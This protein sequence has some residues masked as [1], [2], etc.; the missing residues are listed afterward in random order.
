MNQMLTKILILVTGII[1]VVVG[2][3]VYT[4]GEK[5]KKN[6]KE[7]ATA[8]VVEIQS[9]ID[10][11]S[12]NDTWEYYPIL[13]YKVGDKTYQVEGP[14]S[15]NE[16]KYKVGQEVSILYNANN[17]KEYLIQGEKSH[18]KLLS[19]VFVAAGIIT[20]ILGIY[21]FITGHGLR[22]EIG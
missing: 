22:V 7:E 3:Y 21:Y 16:N 15:H 20:F 9:R 17:K 19:I 1:F 6:C 12:D 8:V 2:V 14:A 11:S 10:S 13:E 5:L 4:N 18:H